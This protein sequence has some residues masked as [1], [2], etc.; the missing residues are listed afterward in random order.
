[1]RADMRLLLR[2]WYGYHWNRS[3]VELQHSHEV[4]VVQ[5]E[6]ALKARE[7]L[8][9]ADENAQAARARLAEVRQQLTAGTRIRLL[10]SDGK[11]PGAHW[12]CWRNGSW[13]CKIGRFPLIRIWRTCFN[14][15]GSKMKDWPG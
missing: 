5:E 11:K 4:A 12:L 7:R 2:D 6:A 13:R 10:C 14:N 8:R 9:A 1:M 15:R 3:Q